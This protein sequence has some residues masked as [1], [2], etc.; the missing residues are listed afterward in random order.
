MITIPFNFRI[1]PGIP[2]FAVSEQGEVYS[3]RM[4]KLCTISK[5]K[6]GY[7][8]VA[9]GVDGKTKTFYVHRLVALT[10]LPVPEEVMQATNKPEV[11]HK[12]GNKNNNRKSN[13]EW[14]TSKQNSDHAIVNG[15]ISYRNVKARNLDTDEELV[16]SSYH[17]TARHF[18]IGEKRLKRHLDSQLAGMHTKDYWVFMY[19]DAGEWPEVPDDCVMANRWDKPY[20]IWM[21]N[22]GN[23]ACMAATLTKFC[24]ATGLKYNSIQPEVRTTGEE[25]DVCGWKIWYCSLPTKEMLYE[26]EYIP[27]YKF[28]ESRKVQVTH[29]LS[30]A[31]AVYSS[32]SAT[33]RKVGI[34]DSTLLY[35][36][37]KKDG[38]HQGMH[39]KYLDD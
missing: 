24:E 38:L 15:L 25:Y 16:F 9:V 8:T 10:F 5:Q 27:D 37:M 28:R 12:D 6:T 34:S 22:K 1:V 29:L 39:F 31:I 13:L 26:I 7:R 32:L 35:A 36:L 4:N 19:Q 30:G 21:G 3:L 18:G 2:Y 20:G 33:S 11:N 17:E 23:T 14:M